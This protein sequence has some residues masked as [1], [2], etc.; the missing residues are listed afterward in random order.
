MQC[1]S[2][3]AE[4]RSVTESSRWFCHCRY[5]VSIERRARNSAHDRLGWKRIVEKV[6]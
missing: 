3:K 6:R 2:F 5:A 1:D 4:K